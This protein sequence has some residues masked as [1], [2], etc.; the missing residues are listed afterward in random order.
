MEN[1]ATVLIAGAGIG[2]LTLALALQKHCGID[3]SSI[4]VYEQ[5][6]R[7][8]R[9]LEPALQAHPAHRARLRGPHPASAPSAG[10]RLH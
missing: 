6:R 5:A 9:N 10:D 3:G 8:R 2:G 4:E 7:R 1:P